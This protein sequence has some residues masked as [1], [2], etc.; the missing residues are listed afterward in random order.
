MWR[1]LWRG[2]HSEKRASSFI[3][4]LFRNK[5]GTKPAQKRV[6]TRIKFIANLC[7]EGCCLS[8]MKGVNTGMNSRM[9]WRFTKLDGDSKSSCPD[10]HVLF[11][12]LVFDSVCGDNQLCADDVTYVQ[13][14]TVYILISLMINMEHT[15][16]VTNSSLNFLKPKVLFQNTPRVSLY[17]HV[18]Q[19]NAANL[20]ISRGV[21]RDNLL[22]NYMIWSVI[23]IVAD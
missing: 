10:I 20:H 23:K 14:H 18:T 17:N 19:R 15:I 11:F 13:N 8:V 5:S 7:Q 1:K 2:A 4:R 21:T 6:E 16:L 9:K 3:W 12:I 22:E